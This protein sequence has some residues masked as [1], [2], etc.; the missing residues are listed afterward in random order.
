MSNRAYL[1]IYCLLLIAVP[2]T[3]L[4]EAVPNILIILL[5]I[6]FP[7]VVKKSQLCLLKNRI[8]ISLLLLAILAVLEVLFLSRFEDLRF[9]SK[10]FLMLG[11]YVLSLPVL[12]KEH[13]K[14]L[15]Y[16]FLLGVVLLLIASSYSIL[17]ETIYNENFSLAVGDINPVLLGDR[18]YVG[19]TYTIAF[20]ICLFLASK[21]NNKL[22]SALMVVLSL[23]LVSFLF[24]IAARTSLLSIVLT[25]VLSIFYI[26][27]IK[28]KPFV[29]L[30]IF[31]SGVS[32][33]FF[34]QNFK[35]RLTLGFKQKQFSFEKVI[36]LEPRY[37]IW[38]CVKDIIKD[39]SPSFFGYGFTTTQEKLNFCYANSQEFN[40]NDQQSW[41]VDKKFN[42]HNQYLNF[43]LSTGV[44][45]LLVFSIT[46]FFCLSTNINI[47]FALA[48]N[49]SVLLFFMVENVLSRQMGVELCVLV[50][51]FSKAIK[52]T[53][54]EVKQINKV[55]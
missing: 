55:E 54:F 6:L 21:T 23:V 33:I 13:I 50:L 41:F 8:F 19:F 38:G 43:Y 46:C 32:L 11:I 52:L 47:F 14:K 9:V 34:N 53:Q 26:K 4:G 39:K 36:K 45:A 27:N 10:L 28:L 51:V 18:P 25:G 3:D 37:Y 1:Y 29:L 44:L 2:F 12:L 24:L 49:V 48:L 22:E 31:V 30:A 5:S 7:F 35:S 16:C 15:M 17:R 20:F 42:T 40:N